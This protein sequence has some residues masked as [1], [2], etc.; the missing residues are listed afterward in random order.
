MSAGDDIRLTTTLERYA[1]EQWFGKRPTYNFRERAVLGGYLGLAVYHHI[2]LCL[3]NSLYGTDHECWLTSTGGI[4]LSNEHEQAIF[5]TATA[6]T[7][8]TGT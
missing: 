1:S 4:C 2:N 3:A 6:H 5:F 7:V 8:V